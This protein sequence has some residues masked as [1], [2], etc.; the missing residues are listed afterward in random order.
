MAYYE[1][2]GY[3]AA[4][5]P[6]NQHQQ[7]S[8][9][10]PQN[11][12]VIDHG[13]AQDPQSRKQ[14]PRTQPQHTG[15]TSKSNRAGL[16]HDG[17]R[18]QGANVKSSSHRDQYENKEGKKVGKLPIQ[19]RGQQ[20]V[21]A[22]ATGDSVNQDE[23][24][25]E[26]RPHEKDYPQRSERHYQLD[27]SRRG[28]QQQSY[29]QQSSA[30]S[31][32]RQGNESHNRNDSSH[33]AHGNLCLAQH[34]DV[35]MEEDTSYPNQGNS[36]ERWRKHYPNESSE[37]RPRDYNA[38]GLNPNFKE[39]PHALFDRPS[40]SSSQAETS[41]QPKSCKFQHSTYDNCCIFLNASLIS[42]ENR[43]NPNVARY[44]CLGQSFS[45]LSHEAEKGGTSNHK[46]PRW[47]YG[48]N[49]LQRRAPS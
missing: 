15:D 22:Y 28:R 47:L 45:Y 4:G 41:S 44:Y 11:F 9:A 17:N 32:F 7:F 18:W 42:Q 25:I 3:G 40:K 6:H 8:Y 31:P 48:C 39:L 13:F 43:R 24:I 20:P 16:E 2:A 46:E 38:T 19:Q 36:G 12:S 33:A 14:K 27:D 23:H 34:N 37:S 21:D 26:S 1:Q 49:K 5:I 10:S 35:F 29:P 30:N